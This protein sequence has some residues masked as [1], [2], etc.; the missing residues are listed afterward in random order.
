[1]RLSLTYLLAIVLTMARALAQQP[2]ASPN[3]IE[4]PAPSVSPAPALTPAAP[5]ETPPPKR[6]WFGRVM[7]PFSG[8]SAT[9]KYKDLKLRGLALVLEISPQPVKLS[10][11]RQINIKLR[12]TN[13]SK[14]SVEL[15]FKTDQRIEIYLT[16][17]GGVVLSKWSDNHAIA[18]KPGLILIN[19]EEQ[20]EYNESI[21][22]R[23]LAPDKV[24][25]ADVFFP[26]YPD[27]RV[28]QKFL[29]AP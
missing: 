4:P 20:L 16:N 23:D 21:T 6:G 29:T 26:Q 19:P 25:I 7:H 8:P 28:R 3:T 5:S 2:T 15:N 14:R 12:M 17:S 10:E 13:Q 27:L 1:M 22:T 24:Y 9:P 18:E 11:I